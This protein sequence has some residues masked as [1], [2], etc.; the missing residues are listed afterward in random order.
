MP[1]LEDILQLREEPLWDPE[2]EVRIVNNKGLLFMVEFMYGTIIGKRQW[3]KD[4]YIALLSSEMT[5][6]DEAFVLLVLENNWDI[7]N[8][9]ARAEPKYTSRVTT[10]NRRNDGWTNEGITRYNELQ[11]N[12]KI[13]RKKDYSHSV[14]K[15][16]MNLLYENERGEDARRK[17]DAEIDDDQRAYRGGSKR[18]R[19]KIK[20]KRVEPVIHLD[21][22]GDEGGVYTAV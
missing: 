7:L 4:K 12:V 21:D 19:L 2:D 22:S 5:T 14:E 8:G 3:K 16:I 10:S 20:Q 13:N 6:S 18:K 9:V 17:R 15:G 11:E 1:S